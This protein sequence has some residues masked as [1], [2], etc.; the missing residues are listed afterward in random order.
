MDPT[1]PEILIVDSDIASVGVCQS[2]NFLGWVTGNNPCQMTGYA[3]HDTSLMSHRFKIPFFPYKMELGAE[4]YMDA[5]CSNCSEIDQQ[6][7]TRTTPEPQPLNILKYLLLD[8]GHGGKKCDEHSLQGSETGQCCFGTTDSPIAVHESRPE[9]S[10]D[11][12]AG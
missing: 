5:L 12:F 3:K 10:T 2:G 11:P 9:S 8:L 4:A 7:A 1:G 6:R